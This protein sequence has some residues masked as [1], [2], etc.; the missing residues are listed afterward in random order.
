MNTLIND[1]PGERLEVIG[2]KELFKFWV[3]GLFDPGNFFA[4]VL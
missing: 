3:P 2:D 1:V 4:L